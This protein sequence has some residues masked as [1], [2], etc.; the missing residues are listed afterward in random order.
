DSA[1]AGQGEALAISAYMCVGSR[2][3]CATTLLSRHT[4]PAALRVQG[5]CAGG[6]ELVAPDQALPTIMQTCTS[7]ATG[8]PVLRHAEWVT[9]GNC[10]DGRVQ[11]VRHVAVHR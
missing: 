11:R 4:M 6:I 7:T 3:A 8:Q 9:P 2:F 1:F 10:L 5:D